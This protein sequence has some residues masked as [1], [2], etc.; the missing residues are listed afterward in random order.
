MNKIPLITDLR[1][2]NDPVG[3]QWL[4]S[5]IP[6]TWEVE[7]GRITVQGQLEKIVQ[8]IPSPK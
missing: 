3:H 6:A 5:V 7:I 4:T 8:K 1:T 2:A